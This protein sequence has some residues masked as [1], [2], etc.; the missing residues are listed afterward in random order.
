MNAQNFKDIFAQ[1]A[2]NAFQSAFSDK[3]S[4]LGETEIFSSNFILSN[5][6]KPK[7][8]TKGR[9]AFPV[10]K[11]GKLLGDN[12]P[13]IANKIV[14]L[15]QSQFNDDNISASATGGFINIQTN[16]TTE[17]KS[18]LSEILEKEDS[19]ADSES[20]NGKSI[21]VEYWLER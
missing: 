6:E 15:L 5:I 13:S 9:F 12:P 11:Y 10:F 17:C 1:N 8:P 14:D 2:A 19:F 3:F 4:E 16:F 21:L 7:D 18:T 20:G